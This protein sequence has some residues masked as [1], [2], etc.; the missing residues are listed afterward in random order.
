MAHGNRS[1][2]VYQISSIHLAVA[3]GCM[4]GFILMMTMD[5]GAFF[6]QMFPK[7]ID[8]IYV[9]SFGFCVMNVCFLQ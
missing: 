6:L 5:L 1:T 7:T 3:R 4:I 2:N 8:I 9:N